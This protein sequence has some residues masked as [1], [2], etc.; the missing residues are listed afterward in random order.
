MKIFD[1]N[2]PDFNI[3]T[4]YIKIFTEK[5]LNEY[6]DFDFCLFKRNNIYEVGHLFKENQF[7]FKK[8]CPTIIIPRYV[9]YEL[10]ELDFLNYVKQLQIEIKRFEI[11][12]KLEAMNKDFECTQ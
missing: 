11:N 7:K 2:S 5:S 1:V 9:A 3:F 8:H 12:G 10:N 4:K 6:P